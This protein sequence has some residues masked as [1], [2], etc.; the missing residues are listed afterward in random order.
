MSLC[1]I[2]AAAVRVAASAAGD[3]DTGFGNA[4]TVTTAIGG[5]PSGAQA[6]VLHQARVVVSRSAAALPR[7]VTLQVAI[8]E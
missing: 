6:L 2:V 5:N 8:C 4:G 1:K 7:T 3:G